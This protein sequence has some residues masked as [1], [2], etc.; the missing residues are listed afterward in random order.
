MRYSRYKTAKSATK[1][2][3]RTN[4]TSAV[5]RKVHQLMVLATN[6]KARAVRFEVAEQNIG[7]SM[8]NRRTETP[9]SAAPTFMRGCWMA[10]LAGT[11]IVSASIGIAPAASADQ[12]GYIV[13]VTVRPTYNFPDFQAALDYGYGLCGRIEAGSSYADMASQIK[14]D[15]DTEDEYTASYLLNQAAQELC[16]AQT[17]NLRQSAAGY[18]PT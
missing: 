9:R 15:L 5:P 6:R 2:P 11:G 14:R 12:L 18:R 7:V 16:P 13:N 1:G 10:L 17:W 8:M 3:Q 4:R